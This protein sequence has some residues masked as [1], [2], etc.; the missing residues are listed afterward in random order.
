[1]GAGWGWGGEIG[2]EGGAGGAEESSQVY[3][4]VADSCSYLAGVGPTAPPSA[5]HLP[6]GEEEKAAYV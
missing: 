5:P 3:L 1:M 2:W 6:R 4:N